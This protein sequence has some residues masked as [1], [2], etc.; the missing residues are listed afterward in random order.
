MKVTLDLL[1][2]TYCEEKFAGKRLFKEGIRDEQLCV[3]SLLDSKDTC[4]GDSGGPIQVVTDA[5]TCTFHIV[6]VTSTGNTCGVG[7]TDSIYTQ[8]ASF[9]DWIEDEV[10]PGERQVSPKIALIEERD[11]RVVF[12]DD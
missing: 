6:G 12:P 11:Y 4:N 3:G 1:N 9:I 8:V 5:S 10:W 2:N 7:R